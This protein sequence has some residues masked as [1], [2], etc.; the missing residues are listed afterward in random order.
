MPISS[1]LSG[2]GRT[3]AQVH[4]EWDGDGLEKL[5]TECYRDSMELWG[6]MAEDFARE[7]APEDKGELKKRITHEVREVGEGVEL[8]LSADTTGVHPQGLNYALFQEIGTTRNAAQPYLRPAMEAHQDAITRTAADLYKQR[9]TF[10]GRLKRAAKRL[11][12]F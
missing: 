9:A 1:S 12:R 2:G 3:A 7:L 4:L 8:I 11:F 5:V 10:F 6:Q